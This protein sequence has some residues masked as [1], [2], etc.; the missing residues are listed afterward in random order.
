MTGAGVLQKRPRCQKLAVAQMRAAE[1]TPNSVSSPHTDPL[2]VPPL[3]QLQAEA[4]GQGGLRDGVRRDQLPKVQRLT[5]NTKKWISALGWGADGKYWGQ[6]ELCTGN[7]SQ[8]QT[9]CPVLYALFVH[10]PY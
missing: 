6:P 10:L 3:G 8:I 5:Q 7:G 1:W 4:Q 9:A 2:L